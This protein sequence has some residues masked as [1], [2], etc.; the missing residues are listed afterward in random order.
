MVM[1]TLETNV[2]RK[3]D[4]LQDREVEI[5][6][7]TGENIEGIVKEVLDTKMTI[8]KNGIWE[9]ELDIEFSEVK[10]IEVSEH[11]YYSLTHKRWLR[12]EKKPRIEFRFS[13]EDLEELLNSYAVINYDGKIIEGRI[14]EYKHRKHG[15]NEIT[16]KTLEGEI[17]NIEDYRLIELE[18]TG[19]SELEH[20][21]YKK[22]RELEEE[23]YILAQEEEFEEIPTDL[24]F[25]DVDPDNLLEKYFESKL[26]VLRGQKVD[27]N[28][29]NYNWAQEILE[30]NKK[31][32]CGVNNEFYKII[33]LARDVNQY[34]SQK[35]NFI[36]KIFIE[37]Q[38]INWT[39]YNKSQK[40]GAIEALE[41][42]YESGVFLR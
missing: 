39:K 6:L 17:K 3:Q 13:K 5:T 35:R 22:V 4:I 8:A 9:N 36:E 1:N 23:I 10:R 16:V 25:T 20:K 27:F 38:M 26:N 30:E 11:P 28:Q 2:G 12:E 14:V 41:Y 29:F 15:S 37:A 40:A 19:I 24:T 31:K 34:Y 32:T 18:I 42:I 7:K 21:G 33:K